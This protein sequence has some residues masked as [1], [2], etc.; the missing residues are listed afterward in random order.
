MPSRR[1]CRT[2]QADHGESPLARFSFC[3]LRPPP[4]HSA[5]LHSHSP[6]PQ[7]LAES[8]AQKIKHT[9]SAATSCATCTSLAFWFCVCVCVS[10]TLAGGAAAAA[11][12]ASE[13]MIRAGHRRGGGRGTVGESGCGR[14][15]K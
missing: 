10:G 5:P 7:D 3:S 12:G 11:G 1:K 8:H 4:P 15:V 6:P 9:L 14:K 13:A 2:V